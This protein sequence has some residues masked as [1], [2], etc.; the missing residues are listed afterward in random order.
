MCDFIHD[1]EKVN[2]PN[3]AQQI[4]LKELSSESPMLVRLIM[5][6]I[7]KQNKMCIRDRSQSAAWDFHPVS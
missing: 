5:K 4:Y 3:N 2:R 1:G 7:H 6:S